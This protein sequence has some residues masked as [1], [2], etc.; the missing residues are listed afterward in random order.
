[1]LFYCWTDDAREVHAELEA[2]GID[3][4]ESEHPFYMRAREFE[5]VDPD[6]CVVVVVRLD[7]ATSAAG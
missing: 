1:M 6:G 5:V 3:V 4:G 7:V 2:A